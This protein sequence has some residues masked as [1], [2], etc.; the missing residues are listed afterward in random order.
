VIVGNLLLREQR[1]R[2]IGPV[3]ALLIE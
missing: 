2:L 1:R 3:A